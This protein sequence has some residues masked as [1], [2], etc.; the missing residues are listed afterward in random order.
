MNHK[1][2]STMQK[3]YPQSF[4]TLY[5][6]FIQ[7]ILPKSKFECKICRKQFRRKSS[8]TKHLKPYSS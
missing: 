4:S 6:K 7:D 2:L 5:M 8:L 1:N 3:L